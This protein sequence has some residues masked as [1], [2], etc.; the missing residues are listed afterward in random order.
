MAEKVI[1]IMRII[2][3]GFWKETNHKNNEK[4]ALDNLN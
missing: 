1:F 2:I 3:S 4:I